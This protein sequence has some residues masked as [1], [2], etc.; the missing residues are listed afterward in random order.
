M[1]SAKVSDN[2]RVS[3]LAAAAHDVSAIKEEVDAVSLTKISNADIVHSVSYETIA[4]I[5]RQCERPNNNNTHGTER[6]LHANQGRFGNNRNRN[7]GGSE[8]L[9]RMKDKFPCRKCGKYGHW[10]S[11]HLANGSLK[12]GISSYDKPQSDDQ[13]T[14]QS[15]GSSSNPSHENAS[16]K[17]EETK[18]GKL[19]T[20]LGFTCSVQ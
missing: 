15:N 8:R 2:H 1:S 7:G 11:E 10:Q 16:Q 5:L 17:C 19:K 13:S 20:A 14:E 4:S 9:R 12:R 3:I 18:S 6:S